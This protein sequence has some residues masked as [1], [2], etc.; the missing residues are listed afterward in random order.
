MDLRKELMPIVT[1]VVGNPAPQSRTL[2]IA[3]AVARAL[4][5]NVQPSVI[6]LADHASVMFDWKNAEL[7]ALSRK[8]A[9][10]DLVVFA[11]PTYKA[12]YTGLLK[13]FLDRYDTNGLGGVTAIAVMSGGSPFHSLAP[14]MTLRPLLVE[15]GA[16]TPT[17]SLYFMTSQLAELDTVVGAWA[18]INRPA[19][20]A[21]LSIERRKAP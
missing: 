15:L 3:E 5:P 20:M 13:A 14:D 12:S 7:Q 16:I 11:S 9:E 19:V 6:D 17:R 4:V 8:V 1:V 18:E 21:M 10:S 2:G